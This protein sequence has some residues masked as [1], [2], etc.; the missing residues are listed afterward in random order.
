MENY[1]ITIH[2]DNTVH[3]FEVGEYLHHHEEICKIKI[4][5]NGSFV[6]SFEPD[7]HHYLHVCQNP[8][9]LNEELLHLLAVEIEAH[10]PLEIIDNS[11]KIKQ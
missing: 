3:H 11:K 5:E 4:F 9:G 2:D 1:P 10:H 6:A 7:Q 8:G